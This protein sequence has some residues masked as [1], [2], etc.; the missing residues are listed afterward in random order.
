MDTPF[1]LRNL[2]VAF[3]ILASLLLANPSPTWWLVEFRLEWELFGKPISHI[4][5]DDRHFLLRFW[6]LILRNKK[7]V[8]LRSYLLLIFLVFDFLSRIAHR[9]GRR[10]IRSFAV[11]I[12]LTFL[13]LGI[14]LLFFKS[15]VFATL[16]GLV[17]KFGH[18]RI[19]LKI[20]QCFLSGLSG[21][22]RH[23]LPR[24]ALVAVLFSLRRLTAL[25]G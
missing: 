25:N 16:L 9:T 24:L 8:N 1:F 12:S 10:N 23:V 6:P 2:D 20:L 22:L 13:N 18:L 15:L 7:E 17:D 5:V 21:E 3:W 11:K 14:L 4:R 19:I